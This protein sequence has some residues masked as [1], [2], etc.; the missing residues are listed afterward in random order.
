LYIFFWFLQGWLSIPM[1]MTPH[2]TT[3][4]L[5]PFFWD[6]PGELVPEENLWS[7]WCKGRLTEADYETIQQGA[8]PS[9]LSSAHLHIP[10]FFTGRMP[11]LPPKQQLVSNQCK[12][13]PGKARF[14]NYISL[15]CVEWD[16]TI[17]HTLSFIWPKTFSE[18]HC[19]TGTDQA[20]AA[21]PLPNLKTATE[22]WQ[23]HKFV[24]HNLLK[25]SQ[26]ANSQCFIFWKTFAS[27]SSTTYQTLQQ[28]RPLSRENEARSITITGWTTKSLVKTEKESRTCR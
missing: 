2:H 14:W 8:T 9:G 26:T 5:R 7:S 24:Q 15:L 1:Q 16:R 22:C 11:F 18:E 28:L 19:K 27:I 12:R 3:T 13:V 21:R 20:L 17:S 4:I 25:S 10:L 6:H 23:C